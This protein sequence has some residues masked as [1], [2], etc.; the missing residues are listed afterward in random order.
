[1]LFRPFKL[2]TSL[3]SDDCFVEF[4]DVEWGIKHN[5]DDVLYISESGVE[6]LL[7]IFEIFGLSEQKLICSCSHNPKSELLKL[8]SANCKVVVLD[9]QMGKRVVQEIKITFATKLSVLKQLLAI[10]ASE[11]IQLEI[12]SM[13]DSKTRIVID[14]SSWNKHDYISFNSKEHDPKEIKK[15]LGLVLSC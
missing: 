12:C 2:R 7:E 4:R 5:D 6:M 8:D 1:M 15:K 10:S 11:E 14:Y 9:K 13:N 3:F